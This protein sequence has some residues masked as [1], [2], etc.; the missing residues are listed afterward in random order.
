MVVRHKLM[1]AIIVAVSFLASMIAAYQMPKIYRAETVLLVQGGDILSPLIQGLAITPSTAHRLRALKEELLSWERLT[2]LAEKLKLDKEAKS[3]LQYER[4]I[5]SLRENTDIKLRQQGTISLSFEGEVPKEAQDIVQTLSDI[6]VD[7]TLTSQK[8][9]TSD[10]I[11][12]IDSQLEEYRAKLEES[13]ERLRKFKE[14]Y[15]TTLPL[16]IRT[17]EQIT[18][19][20]LQLNQLMIDNTEFHPRV[21]ETKKLIAQLE[22]QRN[23]QM[24]Q[25]QE[26]GADV[27]AEDFASLVS[28]VPRQEQHLAKLQR[29]QSV[30][31]RIYD[32]LLQR[33]ETAKI[34]ETLE[35]ADKGP[36]FKILEPAR[37]PLVPVKPNKPLIAIAGLIIGMGL[38]CVVIYLIELS[39][40]SIRSLE[41][42]AAIFDLPVFGS[43][44]PINPEQIILEER[45]RKEA[46]V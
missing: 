13:E 27:S 15:M 36:R 5:N 24:K 3:P 28:S 26:E 19:L 37:L 29:D 20:K 44:S 17:N 25:A 40:T 42:A 43:I 35:N 45:M 33:L 8:I 9:E 4:L 12:F 16:A 34:S 1:F 31:A 6:I 23:R 46:S 7:G 22:E 10:A 18:N 2:L 39:N 11:D 14:V 38:G 30:N 41:E 32:Q 21:I